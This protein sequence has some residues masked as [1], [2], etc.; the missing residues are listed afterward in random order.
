MNCFT[1]NYK[2]KTS[3]TWK[4]K[5]NTLNNCFYSIFIVTK[6]QTNS[7]VQLDNVLNFI[8]LLD[9]TRYHCNNI[10]V[11]CKIFD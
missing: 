11:M 1:N 5:I 4:K 10:L 2:E 3:N 7:T 6:K 9:A 8:R